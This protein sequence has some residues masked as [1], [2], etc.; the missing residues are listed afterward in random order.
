MTG[1]KM[2][3]TK[4]Q[5]AEKKSPKTK[6]K[7]PEVLDKGVPLLAMDGTNVIEFTDLKNVSYAE[8]QITEA[9]NAF[10][11]DKL[12]ALKEKGILEFLSEGQNQILKLWH[13]IISLD[14]HN[15]MFI[16]LF[17]IYIGEILNEIKTT[18]ESDSSP[19]EFVKWRREAFHYK[20]ERYLQQAQQL[21]RLG[22]FA[23]QYAAMGKQ[24]LLDLDRLRKQ[25]NFDDF[26]ELF[27]KHKIP[28]EVTESMPSVDDLKKD[29]FPDISDDLEGDLLRHHVDA[30]ITKNRF[31]SEGVD[32]I[33]FD[34]AFLL[35]ASNKG[36]VPVKDVKKIKRFLD[37]RKTKPAKVKLLN[38]LLLDK[39]KMPSNKTTGPKS[40]LSLNQ[41]LSNF[42]DYCKGKDFKDSDWIASQK[43]LL[44]EELFLETHK[45]IRLISRSFKIK[46]SGKIKRK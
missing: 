46:L 18:V 29:P 1:S 34:Q 36:P 2:A 27:G 41:L 45:Y 30:V 16:V 28:Q 6:A 32:F 39:G 20:H 8:E 19:R 38:L 22:D 11:L 21:A 43:G 37:K 7:V 9:R 26:D 3:K 13:C 23:K 35:A 31:R 17:L 5:K 24:R 10:N 40:G 44:E 15:T 4:S 33:T 25:L 12:K 14:T 42:V